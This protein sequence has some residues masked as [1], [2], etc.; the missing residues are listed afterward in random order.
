MQDRENVVALDRRHDVLSA[1]NNFGE[2]FLHLLTGD[3]RIVLQP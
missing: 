3:G 1:A 2:S